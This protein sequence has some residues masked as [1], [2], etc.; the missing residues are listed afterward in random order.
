[1]LFAVI[2]GILLIPALY[3]MFQWLGEKGGAWMTSKPEDT[4]EDADAQPTAEAKA[5][6]VRG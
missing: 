6:E 1:M 5:T 2:F 4:A 3:I